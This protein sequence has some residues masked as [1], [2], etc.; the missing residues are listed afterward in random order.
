VHVFTTNNSLPQD[1][2]QSRTCNLFAM[3]GLLVHKIVATSWHIGTVWAAIHK[4]L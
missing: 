3:T 4:W 1:R 2:L